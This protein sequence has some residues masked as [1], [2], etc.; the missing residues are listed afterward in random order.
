MAPRNRLKPSASEQPAP[1]QRAP[2]RRAPGEEENIN[3]DNVSDTSEDKDEETPPAPRNKTT[4]VAPIIQPVVKS[5]RALDIDLLFDRG[6]GKQS[7][8]RYCK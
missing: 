6:K 5:N 4:H 3:I 2:I 1:A 8:C 7:V